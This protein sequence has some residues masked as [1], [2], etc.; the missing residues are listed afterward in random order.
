L[1]AS[2]RPAVELTDRKAPLA[3]VFPAAGSETCLRSGIRPGSRDDCR[4]PAAGGRRLLEGGGV[5]DWADLAV[6]LGC[7][8]Q[9]AFQQ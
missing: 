4:F 9:F 3:D 7:F 6:S 8:D 1:T 5:L 2:R